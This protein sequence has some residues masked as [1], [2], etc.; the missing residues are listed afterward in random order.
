AEQYAYLRARL[1]RRR[2]LVTAGAVASGLL[3]GCSGRDVRPAS[4][5]PASPAVSGAVLAPFGRHLAFGA[6]PMRQMR[7]SWQ[8]PQAVR[9]PF[10]RVG[11]RPD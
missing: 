10:V 2:T 6:D 7:I 1:S 3:T 8:V 4:A 9:R 5:P 11:T